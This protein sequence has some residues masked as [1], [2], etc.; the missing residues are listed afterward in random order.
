MYNYTTHAFPKW[1]I[2]QHKSVVGGTPQL[3]TAQMLGWESKVELFHITQTKNVEKILKEGLRTPKDPKDLS[4]NS[5]LIEGIYLLYKS[6]L[7]MT[8]SHQ[9]MERKPGVELSLL[10]VKLLDIIP[11]IY[12][13]YCFPGAIIVLCDIPARLVLYMW[14]LPSLK[15]WKEFC[16]VGGT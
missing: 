8:I 7:A 1:L 14:N 6:R 16:S 12:D 2:N 9:M 3:L 4:F 13:P 10:K 15:E 5:E 11:F